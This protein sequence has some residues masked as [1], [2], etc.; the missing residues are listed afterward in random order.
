MTTPLL[1]VTDL[2]RHY[3]QRR[4]SLFV[5]PRVTRAL[6]SWAGSMAEKGI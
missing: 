4:Q 3:R 5:Q 6:A 2:K 1:Q